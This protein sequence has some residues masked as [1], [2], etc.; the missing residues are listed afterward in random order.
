MNGRKKCCFGRTWTGIFE[1]EL[2][3]NRRLNAVEGV[4]ET[5]LV[6]T[7]FC[8]TAIALIMIG[9]PITGVFIGKRS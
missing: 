2:T 6:I 4:V 9:K 1:L 7:V 3:L 8:N 5:T